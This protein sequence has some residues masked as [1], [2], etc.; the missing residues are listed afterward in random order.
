MILSRYINRQLLLA[1]LAISL[2]LLTASLVTRLSRH[3]LAAAQGEI[4]TSS[5]VLFLLYRSPDL[6]QVVLPLA[7]LLALVMTLGRM[8]SE[9][10]MAVIQAVGVSQA[11]VLRICSLTALI[12][13]LVN[14][15]MTLYLSP[16][17]MRNTALL[18]EEQEHLN[19][20]DVLT[21][22]IFQSMSRGQRV[23]YAE[24]RIRPS[25][26]D[27]EQSDDLIKGAAMLEN[28][29]LYDSRD[30]QI[31]MANSANM[32]ER[33]GRR[34]IVFQ[35]G[36]LTQGLTVN[37]SMVD[38]EKNSSVNGGIN[39]ISFEQMSLILPQRSLQLETVLTEQAQGLGELLN[40]WSVPQ[41]TELFWRI[42]LIIIFP[43]VLLIAV[44]LSKTQ[45]R[46]GHFSRVLPAML[47][48]LVYFALLMSM[49]DLASQQILPA[50]PG[51]LATH[52]VML[53]ISA[54]L[55]HQ[56]SQSSVMKKTS[57]LAFKK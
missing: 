23:T 14:L 12:L 26:M 54:W 28:V 5:L 38:P 34:L 30:D 3:L 52:S 18:L 27:F 20:F 39:L 13:M 36:T 37:P 40:G 17:G 1:S 35:D 24:K 42:S 50:L 48:Y 4:E 2:V 6:L 47:F 29:F 10:E 21:P 57:I 45:P 46:D 49:R 53:V 56:H 31:I 15:A 33:E 9:N 41:Q 55:W 44:P 32:V 16:A 22:G 25:S 11:R 8:Y 51:F 7:F 19:E 43:V